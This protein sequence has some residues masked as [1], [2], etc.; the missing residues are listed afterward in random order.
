MQIQP[1][2]NVSAPSYVM[3]AAAPAAVVDGVELS[4]G[5][6][7]WVPS[8]LRDIKKGLERAAM[9]AAVGE[10]IERAYDRFAVPRWEET[11]ITAES[12]SEDMSSRQF[13][14]FKKVERFAHRVLKAGGGSSKPPSLSGSDTEKLQ[15]ILQYETERAVAGKYR[16]AIKRTVMG[17]L[18]SSLTAGERYE[19]ARL[20][21]DVIGESKEYAKGVAVGLLERYQEDP[22]GFLRAYEERF[23]RRKG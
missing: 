15:A 14:E 5:Q 16:K 6:R 11:G 19:S 23:A 2:F 21:S 22:K 1:M 3:P 20:L 8:G 4:G 10:R 7:D 17:A 18:D 13:T 12:T 9:R